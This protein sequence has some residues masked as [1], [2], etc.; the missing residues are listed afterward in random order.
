MRQGQNNKRMRGRGGGRKGGNTRNQSYESNGP[1]VKVR[2]N[3][4]QIVEKY[5]ALARDA[6]P[7]L[8]LLIAV[9]TFSGVYWPR[10]LTKFAKPRTLFMLPLRT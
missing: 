7:A 9:R 10:W 1:E 8:T 6:S 5:L 4:Q 2:G 3:P